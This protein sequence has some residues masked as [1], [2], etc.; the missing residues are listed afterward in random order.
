[1]ASFSS[2][3]PP[4][5]VYLVRPRAIASRAAAFTCSGVS[6]SGSPTDRSTMSCPRFR[7]AAASAAIAKVADGFTVRSRVEVFMSPP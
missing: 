3:V 4:I 6:K 7:S 2:S 1:M 5:G